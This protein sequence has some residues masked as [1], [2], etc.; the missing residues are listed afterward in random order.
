MYGDDEYVDVEDVAG[1]CIE[2]DADASATQ[3][4]RQ[5]LKHAEPV[6]LDDALGCV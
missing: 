3:E 1:T 6:V 4:C 5:F 2:T